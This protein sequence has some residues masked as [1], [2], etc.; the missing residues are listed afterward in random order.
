[1]AKIDTPNGKVIQYH[2]DKPISN[3]IVNQIAYRFFCITPRESPAVINIPQNVLRAH[4][5]ATIATGRLLQQRE[6]DEESGEFDSSTK[7]NVPPLTDVAAADSGVS[8]QQGEVDKQTNKTR[9]IIQSVT[10]FLTPN[11]RVAPE[12]STT[13]S[14][15]EAKRRKEK[16]RV[17]KVALLQSEVLEQYNCLEEDTKKN[18]EERWE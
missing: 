14:A 16:A 11:H 6:V 7:K 4:A 18:F 1:M 12:E 10:A 5:I 9:A 3:G 13:I 2:I 8:Q 15:K 17:E